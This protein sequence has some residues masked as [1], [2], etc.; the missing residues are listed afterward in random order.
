M[1]SVVTLI[2][3]LGVLSLIQAQSLTF[4]EIY[5]KIFSMVICI[6]LLLLIEEGLFSVTSECLCTEYWLTAKSKLVQAKSVVGP[7]NRLYTTIAVVWDIKPQT[8]QTNK[9]LL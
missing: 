7:T 9:T 1:Q 8:N 5:C 6:L 4:V 2:G 3:D